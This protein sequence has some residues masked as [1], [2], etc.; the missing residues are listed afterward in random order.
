[1]TMDWEDKFYSMLKESRANITKAKGKLSGISDKVQSSYKKPFSSSSKKLRKSDSMDSTHMLYPFSDNFGTGLTTSQEKQILLMKEQI[2]SQNQL[3]EKLHKQITYLDQE[4]EFYKQQIGS[5]SEQVNLLTDKID[6]NIKFTSSDWKMAQVKNE[7]MHEI[8]KLKSMLHVYT[9]ETKRPLLMERFVSNLEQIHSELSIMNKRIGRIETFHLS[10][11]GKPSYDWETKSSSSHNKNHYLLS[12]T[13]ADINSLE[14]Q[15]LRLAIS[16]M[17]SKLDS[18]ETNL[19][20]SPLSSTFSKNILSQS[21]WLSENIDAGAES[22][23]SDLS[24][25]ISSVDE[26]VDYSRSS[27]LSPFYKRDKSKYKSS[28][29][30]KLNLELSDLD[31]SDDDDLSLDADY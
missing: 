6:L 19:E 12:P 11:T 16:S 29:R 27:K 13:N 22:S 15:K 14:L 31:L 8:E 9:Q 10:E 4:R 21:N 20:P 24:S 28:Q 23:I 5:L 18:L 26:E 2:D 3:M 17:N 7:L 30:V 25:I 1:M